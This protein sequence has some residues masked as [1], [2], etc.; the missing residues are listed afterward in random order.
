MLFL[1]KKWVCVQFTWVS[2][3]KNIIRLEINFEFEEV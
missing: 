2:F 1:F 3:K